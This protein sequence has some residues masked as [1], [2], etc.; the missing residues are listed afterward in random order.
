[1]TGIGVD[2]FIQ[3][4]HGSLLGV[5]L[6]S[7]SIRAFGPPDR[8]QVPTSA[9]HTKLPLGL[10]RYLPDFSSLSTTRCPGVRLGSTSTSTSKAPR[11]SLVVVR[12]LQGLNAFPLRV[13][14]RHRLTERVGPGQRVGWNAIPPGWPSRRLSVAPPEDCGWLRRTH[15]GP[16]ARGR[17]RV[18]APRSSP[19]GGQLRILADFVQ[20]FWSIPYTGSGGFRTPRWGDVGVRV[21]FRAIHDRHPQAWIGKATVHGFTAGLDSVASRV[22][23][24]SRVAALR[25]GDPVVKILWVKEAAEVDRPRQQRD[26]PQRPGSAPLRG[27]LGDHEGRH[28]PRVGWTG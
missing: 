2:A 7:A 10:R 4:E 27:R 8:R 5:R 9:G 3:C 6:D 18:W 23:Q 14:R 17:R 24:G 16:G 25:N 13:L 28:R 1:M 15:V 11:R 22:E 12:D 21:C 20:R 26:S 19:D